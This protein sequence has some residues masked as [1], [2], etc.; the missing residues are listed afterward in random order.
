MGASRIF[1]LGVM[2]GLSENPIED[3]SKV[4]ELGF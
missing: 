4:K 1:P 3:L 2:T